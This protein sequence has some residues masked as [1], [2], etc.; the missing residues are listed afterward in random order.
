MSGLYAVAAKVDAGSDQFS[1][2]AVAVVLPKLVMEILL[3]TMVLLV[4]TDY[5]HQLQV[6]QL[7]ELVAVVAE[8]V[9][10][11]LV[12]ELLCLREVAEEILPIRILMVDVLAKNV[13]IIQDLN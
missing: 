10:V 11:D 12:V 1:Q 6:Q 7:H 13:N 5:H 4:E 2:P 9:A 3:M 8:M